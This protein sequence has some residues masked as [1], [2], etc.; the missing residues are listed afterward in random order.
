M[1]KLFT[2]TLLL[3][4]A[5]SAFAMGGR[6][7]MHDNFAEAEKIS[8]TGTVSFSEDSGHIEIAADGKTYE[9]RYPRMFEDELGIKEGDKLTVEGYKIEESCDCEDADDA[10]EVHLMVTKAVFNGKEYSEDTSGYGRGRMMDDSRRGN[11]MDRNERR[12]GFGR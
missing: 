9:L 12:P 3:V 10:D 8:V 5:A 6:E 11:S 7:R 1:K 2:I 4:M